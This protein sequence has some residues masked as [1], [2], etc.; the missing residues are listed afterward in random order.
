MKPLRKSGRYYLLDGAPGFRS[1][2]V[3]VLCG[4]SSQ[5]SL[6]VRLE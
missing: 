5:R 4:D 6:P 1:A 3:A 2:M